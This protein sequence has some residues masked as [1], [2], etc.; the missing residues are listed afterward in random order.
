MQL[1]F[2]DCV[3]LRGRKRLF[4]I[5]L[6]R[7][8]SG[9][10]VN[11]LAAKVKNQVLSR[12]ATISASTNDDND[13][14]KVIERNPIAFQNVLAFLR[15][16]QQE[17]SAPPDHVHAV[18]NEIFDRLHQPHLFRLAMSHSQENHAEVFLHLG[19]LKE[20]V[21]NDLR[22]APAFQFDYDPHSI[23]IGFVANVG[24]VFDG[25]VVN[26][27]GDA[28][29]EVPLIHLIRDFGDDDGLAV[30][31]NV[32]NRR[33]GAHYEAATAVLVGLENAGFAVDD[34][35]S[36]EVRPLHDLQEFRQR[37]LRIVDQ[38]DRGIHDLGQIVRRDVRRHSH[39]NSV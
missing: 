3:G 16:H 5:E 28:L 18:V 30:L 32:L 35:V 10:D 24:D 21:E 25:L 31:S 7:A 13:V 2:E 34:A 15:F 29:D 9:V 26:Q 38:H 1:Q 23:A 36:W 6:G 37:G 8:P 12:V 27:L 39:G 17:R 20:L 14:I 19:V 33:F 4:R 22:F 11:F